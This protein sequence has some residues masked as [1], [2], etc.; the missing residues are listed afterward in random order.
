MHAESCSSF[1]LR[2][3]RSTALN[4]LLTQV[5]SYRSCKEGGSIMMIRGALILSAAAKIS[6]FCLLDFHNSVFVL[7]FRFCSDSVIVLLSCVSPED[8]VD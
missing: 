1:L 5:V 6:Y 2:L 3:L 4:F 7:L 8:P